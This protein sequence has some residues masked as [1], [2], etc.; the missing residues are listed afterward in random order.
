M[1]KFAFSH[2]FYKGSRD[3]FGRRAENEKSRQ[4]EVRKRR[5]FKLAEEINKD[6]SWFHLKSALQ[7]LLSRCKDG[8]LA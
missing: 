7:P 8:R 3:I 1:S 4:Q 5:Q 6:L 2:I